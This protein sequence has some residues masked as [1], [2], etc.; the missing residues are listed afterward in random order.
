[1][2]AENLPKSCMVYATAFVTVAMTFPAIW[3]PLYF[4]YIGKDWRLPYTP[5]VVMMIPVMVFILC[6]PDTPKFY[7]GKRDFERCR[8][9]LKYIAHFNHKEVAIDASFKVELE[10]QEAENINSD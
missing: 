4:K 5:L 7:Y 1:M 8:T 9:V 6:T 2:M 3:T 10:N